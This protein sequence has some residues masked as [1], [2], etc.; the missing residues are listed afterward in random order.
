MNNI[1]VGTRVWSTI[2]SH[3]SHIFW[4]Y[5][6]LKRRSRFFMMDPYRKTINST[7]ASKFIL[8]EAKNMTRLGLGLGL[9]S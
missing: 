8:A 5:L 6:F 9:E 3:F 2:E 4:S 1:Q 7:A